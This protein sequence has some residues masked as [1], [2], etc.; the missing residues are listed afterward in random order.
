MGEHGP[1]NLIFAEDYLGQSGVGAQRLSYLRCPTRTQPTSPQ[2]ERRHSRVQ[3]HKISRFDVKFI[4]QFRIVQVEDC[5]YR[6]GVQR[7]EEVA[8]EV[9]GTLKQPPHM[10]QAT[11]ARLDK[12]GIVGTQPVHN[13]RSKL[14]LLFLPTFLLVVVVVLVLQPLAV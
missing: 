4:T 9:G 12:A 8:E 5:G 11:R 2:I 1:F 13:V 3:A 10:S 7:T 14:I 6:A